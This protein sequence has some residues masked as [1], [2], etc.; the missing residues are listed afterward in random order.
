MNRRIVI[1]LTSLVLFLFICF[2]DIFS[3]EVTDTK[4]IAFTKN[5]VV[6]KYKMGDVQAEP[7]TVERGDNLWVILVKNYGIKNRQFYFFCRITKSLNPKLM[8]AHEIVP[9]QVLLIPFKYV[10]HFKVDKEGFR[11]V[12]LD[13]LAAVQ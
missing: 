8:N 4:T 2:S 1:P 5:V 9:G 10:P 6:K 11:S 3:Q 7:Y 12:L 13:G